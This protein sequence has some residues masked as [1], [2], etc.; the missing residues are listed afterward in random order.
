MRI[1]VGGEKDEADLVVPR[2]A[3]TIGILKDG[4]DVRLGGLRHGRHRGDDAAA[5]VV[6]EDAIGSSTAEGGVRLDL[7]DE[8]WSKGDLALGLASMMMGDG[9]VR[10]VGIDQ[11]RIH[12]RIDIDVGYMHFGG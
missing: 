2:H 8:R 6:E 9:L 1:V 5:V 4:V 12:G 3:G 7:P 10:L 11:D